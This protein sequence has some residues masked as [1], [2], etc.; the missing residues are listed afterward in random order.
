MCGMMVTTHGYGVA[1]WVDRNTLKLGGGGG[2]PV[3]KY[4]KGTELYAL[5]E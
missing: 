1:F 2:R 4:T 3:C 5:K